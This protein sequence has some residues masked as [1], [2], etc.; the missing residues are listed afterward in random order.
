MNQDFFA[1]FQQKSDNPEAR[2]LAAKAADKLQ[3]LVEGGELLAAVKEKQA[4]SE[5]ENKVSIQDLGKKLNAVANMKDIS[6]QFEL[7][8]ESGNINERSL[9]LKVIDKATNEVVSQFPSETSIKLAR[10]LEQTGG[11]GQIANAVV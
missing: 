1:R 5:L 10:M 3:N 11:T 8:S 2:Q 4:K 9:I 7:Q 6:F